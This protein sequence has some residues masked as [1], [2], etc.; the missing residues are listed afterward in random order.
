MHTRVLRCWCF[1]DCGVAAPA[2]FVLALV[3]LFPYFSCLLLLL[4]CAPVLR[5]IVSSLAVSFRCCCDAGHDCQLAF[6]ECFSVLL[7]VS[8]LVALFVVLKCWSANFRYNTHVE[9]AHD[10]N[11]APVG[12]SRLCRVHVQGVFPTG[13]ALVTVVFC[14]VLRRGCCCGSCSVG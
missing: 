5:S 14:H 2:V 13:V 8:A 7:V 4:G 1:V 9:S 11:T 6:G 12:A 10:R 3:V